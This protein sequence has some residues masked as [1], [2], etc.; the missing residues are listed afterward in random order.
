M[1]IRIVLTPWL[2]PIKFLTFYPAIAAATLL[3]GW[4]RGLAVLL[5][6]A[7]TAWYLFYPPAYSFEIKDASTVVAL[8]GFLL[9][10]GFLVVLVAGM[11]DLIKRLEF[12]NLAQESLFQELQHRVANNLQVVVAMLQGV[13]RDLSDEAT[14]EAIANAQDRIAMMSDLHR[15]LYDRTAYE[16]GLAPL[17][18]DVLHEVFRDLPVL[19]RVDIASDIDLSL[20]QMTAISLLVNEAAMNAAK[21]VFRKGAGTTFKVELLKQTDGLRLLI[22]DDGPGIRR[23]SAGE[24]QSLGMSIMQA[25]ARQLGGS[26]RLNGP[27]GTTLKVEFPSRSSH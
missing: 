5:L 14:A 15:R 11:T 24:R 16:N 21:H 8:V 22:H 9:V 19:V 18:T 12:A 7:A 25:F 17:M 4:T 3:C 6:S 13:R 20:D 26:L 27:T 1:A 2:D 23:D 10:G